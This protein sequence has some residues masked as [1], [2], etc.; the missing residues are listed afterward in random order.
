LEL[1]LAITEPVILYKKND[2][3]I[4]ID[5]L[6]DGLTATLIDG[7][8]VT[9]TLHDSAGQPVSGL[10]AVALS[11][12]S[13]GVYRGQVNE[14]FDPAVGTYTLLLDATMGAYTGHWELKC[15]VKIR[16]S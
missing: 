12:V 7:A 9:A 5:G 16:K 4:E 8:T 11:F 15:K 14:T 3:W 10:T 6:A 13:S 2:Q 1:T